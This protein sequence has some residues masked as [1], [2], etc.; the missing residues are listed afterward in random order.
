MHVKLVSLMGPQLVNVLW[1]DCNLL[2]HPSQL[3]LCFDALS[4][5]KKS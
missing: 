2:V 5:L 3:L 4:H 1:V